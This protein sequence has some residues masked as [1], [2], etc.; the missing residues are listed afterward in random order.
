M[1]GTQPEIIF[2]KETVGKLL[3]LFFKDDKT[4]A[5]ND[6]V[7]LMTEMLKVFV[8]EAARRAMKQAENEDCGSVDLEHIEKILPQLESPH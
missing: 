6:A 8:V 5:S 3:T 1:A 7:I 4:K 2:K